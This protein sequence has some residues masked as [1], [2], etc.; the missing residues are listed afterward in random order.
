MVIKRVA[1]GLVGLSY[2]YGFCR[3]WT[4]PLWSDIPSSSVKEVTLRLIVSSITGFEYVI[5]PFCMMKYRNLWLR[6]QDERRQQE[7][8]SQVSPKK[9]DRDHHWREFDFFHPRAF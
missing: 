4:L 5:P 8:P 6:L 7:D 3:S 2:S 9:P 1:I